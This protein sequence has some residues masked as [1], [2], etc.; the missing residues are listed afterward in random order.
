M[1]ILIRIIAGLVIVGIGFIFIWKTEA[2][3]RSIG[4]IDWAE[5]KLGGTRNFYKLLGII[6]IFIGLLTMTGMIGGFIQ[7]TIGRLFLPPGTR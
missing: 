2:F 5:R 4:R 3:L 1:G 6:V 7:G